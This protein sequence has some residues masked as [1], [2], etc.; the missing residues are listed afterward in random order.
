[1][2]ENYSTSL[3]KASSIDDEIAHSGG[4][5]SFTNGFSTID[6]NAG[7]SQSP[8][9]NSSS[10][11]SFGEPVIHH[12]NQTSQSEYALNNTNTS[13][14]NTSSQQSFSSPSF[15][16]QRN[17]S[18]TNSMMSSASD[19]SNRLASRT[20]S[21]FETFRQWSKSAYKCTRQIVSEKLGKSSR[22]V[23]PELD[24]IIENLR[25]N[26]RKYEQLLFLSHALAHHFQNIVQTQRMLTDT[27]ATLAQKSPELLDEFTS[28]CESQRSLVRT[29]ETLLNSINTFTS[30]L[31]TLCSKT[32]E[33]TL[34]TVRNYEGARLE[35]DAYRFDL[36]QLQNAPHSDQKA[37]Q[38][39]QIEKDLQTYKEKYEKLKSDVVIKMK[40]L[41]EN[42]IKVM[43]K[44]LVVFQNAVAAYYSSSASALEIAYKPTQSPDNTENSSNYKSF[45]EQ[46]L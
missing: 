5:D 21:T 1:M 4:S 42:R 13:S 46:K 33:D 40:F 16:A 38:I 20:I 31:T 19:L 7:G 9:L 8:N 27:F 2:S 24:L 12:A 15:N 26:R 34:Q 18:P 39:Q 32:M 43:R 45:L 22:T 28:N 25:E 41:D 36:E 3:A 10:Y 44:Q 35:Y 23:D 37:Q 6:L 14:F 29:G 11:T 17:S 30:T